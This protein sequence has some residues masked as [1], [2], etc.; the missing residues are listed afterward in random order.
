MLNKR[1]SL[2]SDL[3]TKKTNNILRVVTRKFQHPTICVIRQSSTS[4]QR[5][6]ILAS[7]NQEILHFTAML[8]E[9]SSMVTR[10]CIVSLICFISYVKLAREVISH[11][12]KKP[13][14]VV[15]EQ[16]CLERISKNFLNTNKSPRISS[17]HTS[18]IH[19]QIEIVKIYMEV[20]T[21]IAGG[22]TK[23]ADVFYLS[24]QSYK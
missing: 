8:F 14:I 17:F 1:L 20:M 11:T 4:L 23:A 16:V 3:V 13:E 12:Q 7:G 9:R 18:N 10:F 19:S 5:Q 15:S 6:K 21:K 24:G 2:R 22:I